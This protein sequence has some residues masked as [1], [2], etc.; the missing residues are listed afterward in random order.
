[1]LSNPNKESP[2]DALEHELYDPK[3]KPE[4]TG[5]H[6]VHRKRELSLPTSWGE[7]SPVIVPLGE[8][9][10]FSFGVKLLFVSLVALIVA[11]SFT[12][13]RVFSLRNVV[14]Q[15]NIDMVADVSPY[16]E[17]GE[18]LPLVLTVRNRNQ[19][20]LQDVKV[21]MSYKQG[22]G[23]QDELEKVQEKRDMGTIA[24]NE[25]K[26]QDYSIIMY[27]SAGETRDISLKLEYKVAGSNAVFSKVL[28]TP[29]ILKTPP[30][31]VSISGEE[32]LSIGQNGTFVFT[33]LNN[34]A[35]TTLPSVLQ[36][37]LPTAFT[38]TSSNPSLLPRATSWKVDPLKTGE[39]QKFS[40]TGYF[41]GKEG[42]T[43]TFQAKIGSQG[44]SDKNIGIVYAVETR[45]VRLRASPLEVSFALGTDRAI[46]ENL[47]YGDKARIDITYTNSSLLAL[48]DVSVT[49]SL[50]GDAALYAQIDPT[51]GYYDSIAKTITWNK[52]VLPDLAVLPP[53][54]KGQVSVLVPIVAKGN[55]SPKLNVSLVGKAS[56]KGDDDVVVKQE[57]GYTVYGSA[58]LEAKTLYKTASFATFGPVPP[59]ANT[60]TLYAVHLDVRS[61]NALSSTKVSFVL[62]VYV[63]WINSSTDISSVS[64]NET[65]R[66]VTWNIGQMAEGDTKV[67]E[68]G[69]VVKPSQSHVGKT[70]TITSS[71][72]LEA[73]EVE[74]RTHLKTTLSPLTVKV[75]E[76]GLPAN[77]EVVQP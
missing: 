13:W 67:V 73:D 2:L 58:S 3:K 37:T 24:I 32:T 60:D 15:M 22:N 4:E 61:Q 17:G 30:V 35:T 50:S 72:V 14:S 76:Q 49:L 25:F 19:S 70:P 68:V 33:V 21:T 47:K 62:P 26:K 6:G 9:K 71:L 16:V 40:L 75:K 46:S 52:A 8:D 77:Q 23:A 55:N 7:D 59:R 38:Q 10:G 34:S 36:L 28:S 74:S 69:L 5:V 51:T 66:T 45:D 18:A 27:G 39:S 1:M 54:G 12:A 43:A 57:K 44:E 41:S 11:L 42:E 64:Y 56:S 65:T 31:S 20:A 29:V 63:S 48:Q 53:G